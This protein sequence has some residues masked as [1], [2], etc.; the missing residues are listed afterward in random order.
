MRN[1][2]GDDRQDRKGN[3]KRDDF[4]GKKNMKAMQA[5]MWDHE[6]DE[7]EGDGSEVEVGG[8]K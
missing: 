5:N 7:G 2:D 1:Q 3:F 6:S 8:D 4:K